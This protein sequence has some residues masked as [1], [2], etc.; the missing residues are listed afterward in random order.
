MTTQL[1]RGSPASRRPGFTL[2]ELLVVIAII[3]I[4][5]GLTMPAV[6][7]SREAGRRVTC[8][9][10]LK[11]IGL[12]FQHHHDQFNAFP[13]GGDNYDA[14]VAIRSHVAEHRLPAKPIIALTAHALTE[15]HTRAANAG[16]TGYETK[17]LQ[18]EELLTVLLAAIAPQRTDDHDVARSDRV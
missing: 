6:Q 10:N 16:M 5:V 14:T 7:Q 13:T 15:S 18:K 2:I 4:L 1:P 11:Q 17:P 12:A 9:N 3:G 8:Q